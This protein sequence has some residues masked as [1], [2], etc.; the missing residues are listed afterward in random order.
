MLKADIHYQDKHVQIDFTDSWETIGKACVEMV[1]APFDRLTAKNVEFLAYSG[2]NY[3]KLQKVVSED[4][5]LRDIF[6]AYKKLQYGSKEFSQQFANNYRNFHSA[7][8]VNDAYIKYR[9]EEYEALTSDALDKYHADPNNSYYELMKIFDIPV[10]FT[11]ARIPMS[12]VPKG[13]YRYEVRHDDDCQGIMCQLAKGIMINHWGT[14]L[15]NKPIQ[16]DVDGFRDID[17][18]KDI[19]YIDAPDMTIK[20]Y[21]NEYKSKHKEKER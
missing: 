7:Y 18:E 4:D 15:S 19:V 21:Q 5:T 3:G 17:E 20:E 14:I 12:H 16:L 2:R 13:L 10:I 1:D 6:L 9:Q 8:E 11:P